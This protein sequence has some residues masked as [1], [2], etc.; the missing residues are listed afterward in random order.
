MPRCLIGGLQRLADG[1][2]SL[3]L[4]A[5]RVLGEATGVAPLIRAARGT[6]EDGNSLGA[7]TRL[8]DGALAI[9]GVAPLPGDELAAASV[10]LLSEARA[11]VGARVIAGAGHPRGTLIRDIGRLV[12]QYGGEARDWSKRSTRKAAVGGRKFEIHYYE[13]V[14]TGERAEFKTKLLD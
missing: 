11:G 4:S 7:G 1:A 5:T 3:A 13:N 14:G 8:I 6:D 2:G 12:E 10:R 9:A